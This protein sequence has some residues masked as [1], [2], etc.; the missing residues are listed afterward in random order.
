M[1]W[2]RSIHLIHWADTTDARA[3]LS[4]LIRRLIRRTVRSLS[5]LSFPGFEQ[6]YRPG[7]DGEVETAE[8]N[9]FVP[10]GT[11]VWEMS[12]EQNIKSKADEDFEK[13]TENIPVE[14]QQKSTFVFVTP[15]TWEK[16]DEWARERA[17]TS[18]WRDVKALD[19]N[20]LEHWLELAIDVDVWFSQ[21]TGRITSGVQDLQSYWQGLQG[22]AEHRLDATVFTSS[23]EA[24]IEAITKWLSGPPNSIFLQTNGAT[25][26]IDFIAALGSGQGQ[27]KLQNGL[28]VQTMDAWRDLSGSVEGLI[29][30]AS[31]N[32]EIEPS[33]VARAVQSGHYAIVTGPRAN[34]LSG[35]GETLRRQDCYSVREALAKSGFPDSQA[36]TLA[37]GSCGSSSILKRL[38]TRHPATAFPDWARPDVRPAL[39]AFA[40]VGGW[41]HVDPTPFARDPNLPKIGSDPPID[42][43][44]VTMLV[45]CNREQ[46]DQFIIR[47]HDGLEPLFIQFGHSILV[48]SRE[49]A[50]YLLGGS[51]SAEHLNRFRDLALMVLQEDDP[52]FELAPDQRWMASLYGKRHCISE[53]L[54][55][56]LVET[57]AL[58][59]TY[60]TA[61]KPLAHVDFKAT[62]REI[63]DQALPLGA[64]WQR[65][66][67]FGHNLTIVAEADPKLFLARVEADLA[68]TDPA[69]P[70]LFQDQS[71]SIFSGVI[72]SDLLWSLEA[73][74]W[75]EDYLGRVVVC[76][77]KLAARDPG[78]RYANR[79]FNSLREIFLLWLWH[80]SASIEARV[81]ALAEVLK[82]EP[83]TGWK[84]L[85]DLLP[86]GGSGISHNTHMPRWRPWADGWS[87]SKI[88]RKDFAEYALAV[89]ELAFQSAGNDAKRWTEIVEGMLRFNPQITD[90]VFGVLETICF[91]PELRGEGHFSLWSKLRQLHSRH[92]RF[93]GA[94]WA[95]D[96]GIRDRMASICERLRPSD[97]VLCHH[98]LF[99]YRAE[100]PGFDMVKDHEAHDK[101]LYD[102]RLGA[103]REIVVQFDLEGVFRL[104][105]LASDVGIVGYLVGEYHLLDLKEDELSAILASTEQRR[106]AFVGAYIRSR[107]NV[108][109]WA[110]VDSI[111]FATW[112]PTQLASF[113]RCLPFNKNVWQRLK[114]F[115]ADVERAYWQNVKSFLNKPDLDEMRMAVESLV[116]VGREFAAIELLCYSARTGTPTIPSDLIADV[117]DHPIQVN[118]SEEAA[119]SGEVQYAV[120]QLVKSLQEDGS[121]NRARLA[122]IEWKFLPFLDPQFSDSRPNTLV[123]AIHSEPEFFV[124][125]LKLV[126]RGENDK[127]NDMPHS[128]QDQLRALNANKL[129]DGLNTLPGTLSDKRVDIDYLRRWLGKVHSL[130][131]ECGRRRICDSVLGQLAA[132]ALAGPGEK[133]PS[134]DVAK[135]FEE[136]GS[137]E[138]FR[139][140][141]IGIL[142]SQGVVSRDPTAGG[143]HERELVE[144][145]QRLADSIRE[146]SSKFADAFSEVARHYED[147]AR[148]EDE[149]AHRRRVGR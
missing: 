29:L 49:D 24:E 36:L 98:W 90:R 58:M 50:W 92:E 121:F 119:I 23:R 132:R 60:P 66:A 64:T 100:L 149:E 69:L 140:F 38:V 37:Q 30:L 130:S 97:P 122:R 87:R 65:W 48:A 77:A 115:G 26:G 79:P 51:I 80:T 145:Y 106:I 63:L 117:L 148:R 12:V 116:N 47:W 86:D 73:L 11:S 62:V 112:A 43:D 71:S 102:A 103:L 21:R 42:M 118:D 127:P 45:G 109:G 9:Q 18:S 33:D 89:A 91:S 83:A 44:L 114:H 34:I 39:A 84:L 108:D 141:V 125:I 93:S 143:A 10:V 56:S 75:A 111:S 120:Q 104:I 136:K 25:D 41:T 147:S 99:D 128:E 19:V 68:S 59:A 124:G 53:D 22:I 55:R 129:L 1:S 78:G 61:E 123:E 110:F 4:V 17:A 27:D 88:R 70:Q 76:L 20:D 138:L 2:T 137:E 82:A 5:A 95:F 35:A 101:A 94:G 67:S 96:K 74:A 135:L 13:R 31:P 81:S 144:R 133:W 85:S 107:F 139:G 28:I 105:E 72:H 126:Y 57:L 134:D 7:F 46:L 8:G 16:K 131:E 3:Q 142:N 113:V 15:R 6:V 40:L 52:K 146:I 32:L 14:I 54:R